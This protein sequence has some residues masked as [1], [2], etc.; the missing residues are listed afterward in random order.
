LD[1]QKFEILTVGP[2]SADDATPSQLAADMHDSQKLFES[3]F[4]S[5]LRRAKISLRN[6][7]S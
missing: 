6:I 2:Y 7:E 1:F 5:E 4:D 3:T